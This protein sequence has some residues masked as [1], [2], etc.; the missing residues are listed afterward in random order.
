MPTVCVIV[1]HSHLGSFDSSDW[2]EWCLVSG[3]NMHV[4]IENVC[5]GISPAIPHAEA[6]HNAAFLQDKGGMLTC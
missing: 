2:H 4:T 5:V 3:M 1:L 6:A